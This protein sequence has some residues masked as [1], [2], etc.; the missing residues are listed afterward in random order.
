VR[1]S[2]AMASTGLYELVRD[3]LD[4]VLVFD[5]IPLGAHFFGL[6]EEAAARDPTNREG[7]GRFPF[8]VDRARTRPEGLR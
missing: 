8:Q 2:C 4:P 3:A 1:A 7:R 5:R 6:G